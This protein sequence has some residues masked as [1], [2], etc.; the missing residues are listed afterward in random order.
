MYLSR[1]KNNASLI[2]ISQVVTSDPVALKEAL[3][4]L[5]STTLQYG[6][7]LTVKQINKLTTA[8]QKALKEIEEDIPIE[9]I[10]EKLL[11]LISY[12]CY[13]DPKRRGHPK[14]LTSKWTPNYDL[15]RTVQE[16]DYIHKRAELAILKQ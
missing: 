10:K 7:V 6:L 5:N 4:E 15:Q 13:P 16:L 9:D 12:L 8:V 2:N 11:K 3:T 14:I 1:R